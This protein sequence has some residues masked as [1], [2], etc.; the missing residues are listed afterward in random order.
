V[1]ES[2]KTWTLFEDYKQIEGKELDLNVIILIGICR[3]YL[4]ALS[5]N[6]LNQL[7]QVS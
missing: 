2:I 6:Q 5:T 7:K 1:E 4:D 3:E